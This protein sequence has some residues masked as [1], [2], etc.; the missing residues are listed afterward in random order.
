MRT[1][2]S[3]A[4][5]GTLALIPPHAVAQQRLAALH[6]LPVDGALTT[7]RPSIVFQVQPTVASVENALS[8]KGAPTPAE[9][10]LKRAIERTAIDLHD[11]LIICRRC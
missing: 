1:I 3:A 8:L 7:E 2:I 9:L 5:L 6:E 4:I 11:K 10:E